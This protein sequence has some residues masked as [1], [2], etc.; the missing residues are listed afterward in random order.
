MSAYPAVISG[1]YKAYN[2][3]LLSVCLCLPDHCQAMCVSVYVFSPIIFPF[4]VQSVS[5][6]RKISDKFF[7][8]LLVVYNFFF[9]H[10]FAVVPVFAVMYPVALVSHGNSPCQ[11]NALSASDSAQSYWESICALF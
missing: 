2:I 10:M 5:C 11:P 3:A 7:S 4:C 9:T 6:Q 1:G 8:G